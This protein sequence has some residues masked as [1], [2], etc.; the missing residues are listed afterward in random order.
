[1]SSIAWKVNGAN[2]VTLIQRVVNGETICRMSHGATYQ[3]GNIIAAAPELLA[4]VRR[5]AKIRQHPAPNQR[6]CLCGQCDMV[7]TAIDLVNQVEGVYSHKRIA[8]ELERTA[9]GDGFYGNSLKVAKEI[10]QLVGEELA[11]IQR[12]ET[13]NQKAT[14]HVALQAIAMR[15]YEKG[16][17]A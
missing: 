2:G 9:M 7:R 17:A 8:W 5:V 11:V 3:E 15:I 14:D 13:G 6:E 1:M 12:F 16:G 10:V 4:L